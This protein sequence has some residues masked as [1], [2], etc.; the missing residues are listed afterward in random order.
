[1]IINSKE[2]LRGQNSKSS[3]E[4][5]RPF[6]IEMQMITFFPFFYLLLYRECL[7]KREQLSVKM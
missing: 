3:F 4:Y 5:L 2:F 7:S 1:M 6:V